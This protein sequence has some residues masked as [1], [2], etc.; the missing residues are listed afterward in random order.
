MIYEPT[1]RNVVVE[2]DGVVFNSWKHPGLLSQV[3]VE[4]ST[5]KSS[6]ANVSIYDPEFRYTDSYLNATGM[7]PAAVK[8]WM[9]FGPNPHVQ[10]AEPIHDAEVSKPG[11]RLAEGPQLA[12]PLFE[13]VLT[14]HNWDS[15]ISTFTFYDFTNKMKQL[16]RSRY[17]SNVTD[18]NLLRKL[19]NEYGLKF[20]LNGTVPD[21]TEHDVIIQFEQTDWQLAREIARRS[22]LRL[23]MRNQTLYAQEAGRAGAVAAE[24]VY[25][26]Q[27]GDFVMLRGVGLNHKLPENRRGRPGRVEMR[28]RGRAGSLVSGVDGG[29]GTRGTD[30]VITA[31]DANDSR[32]ARRRARARRSLRRE[33]AF[34][35]QVRLLPMFLRQGIPLKQGETVWLKNLGAFY[36]GKY[37]IRTAHYVFSA[38]EFSCELSL[39]RDVKGVKQGSRR[40]RTRL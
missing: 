39:K 20:V 32:E 35:H 28:A 4:F 16:R 29:D 33:D 15:N 22:G 2:L 26:G 25:K 36:S 40:R 9:G 21:S 12:P 10:V 5:D 1:H 31:T 23:Y 13:G 30:Q 37:L 8:I 17:H 24:L 6:E 11:S 7:K 3:T 38:R 14:R 19:A 18:H 34:E 27:D